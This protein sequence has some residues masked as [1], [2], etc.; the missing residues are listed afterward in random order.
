MQI[1]EQNGFATIAAAAQCAYGHTMFYSADFP[2]GIAQL[3]DAT[4]TVEAGQNRILTFNVRNYLAL[5][6]SFTGEFERAYELQQSV[7]DD[8]VAVGHRFIE[9]ATRLWSSLGKSLQGNWHGAL[10][11]CDAAIAL[12]YTTDA[13]YMEG[14]SRCGRAHARFMSSSQREDAIREYAEGLTLLE[15]VDHKLAVSMYEAWYA[16]I[17]ALSGKLPHARL[18]AEKALAC[19]ARQEYTGEVVALRALAIAESLA[20]H[21]DWGESDALI[22]QALALAEQRMQR[23]DYAICWL[24]RGEILA[25]RGAQSAALDALDTAA[26][27]FTDLKMDWWMHALEAAREGIKCGYRATESVPYLPAATALATDA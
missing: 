10:T 11:L 25:R 1:A 18:H 21:P 24:R 19:R 22:A 6:Y 16:E 7:L 12:G 8:A 5:Q 4:K 14:Y 20:T 26:Q 2:S 27:C 15:R 13:K 17:C 23:P 9:Q 3:E